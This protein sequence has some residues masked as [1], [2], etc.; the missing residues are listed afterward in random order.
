MA[1]SNRRN[2][3]GVAEA[4]IPAERI[5]LFKVFMSPTVDELWFDPVDLF[6]FEV[7]PLH[8]E[9]YR[10]LAMVRSAE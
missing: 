8:V 10:R 7:L 9:L 4:V 6:C 3:S 2:P 5:P 1:A